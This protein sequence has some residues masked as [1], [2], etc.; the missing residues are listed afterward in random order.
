MSAR[1]GCPHLGI[2]RQRPRAGGR[3]PEELKP[4]DRASVSL[5][6]CRQERAMIVRERLR[7][8][9]LPAFLVLG[10]AAV[11]LAAPLDPTPELVLDRAITAMGGPPALE[12]VREIRVVWVGTQDLLAV[13]QSRYAEKP[14]PER[15]Q[16]TLILDVPGRRGSLRNEGV[17]SD[18]TPS[19]WRDTIL[20]DGGYTI[21]LKTQRTIDRTAEAAQAI[22]ER[23]L[24]SIPQLALREL[25][26]RRAELRWVGREN[27]DGGADGR[28]RRGS[29]AARTHPRLVRRRDGPPRRLFVGG[30]IRRGPHDVPVPL[31]AISQGRRPRA[32][33]VRVPLHDR[34]ARLPG[35]RRPRRPPVQGRRAIPGSRRARRTPSPS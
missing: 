34:R 27:L 5:V 3:L 29:S 26:K 4:G 1:R 32:L 24:W 16:E 21:N 31:Q 30:A 28:P 11:A 25:S 13:Y 8:F 22:W 20:A 9:A 19:M 12:A 2:R 23:W 7:R 17:Q 15:R 18:G 35:L 33:S 6:E 14:A 10:P